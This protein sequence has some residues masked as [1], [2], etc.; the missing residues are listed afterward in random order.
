M[1]LT[2]GAIGGGEA[3]AVIVAVTALL[4][5]LGQGLRWLLAREYER[6]RA[7]S[8]KEESLKTLAE[9]DKEIAEL[10]AAAT[11]TRERES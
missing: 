10:R 5:S 2:T 3:A 8:Y 4:G 1:Y 6:G 9:K 11:A 7:A